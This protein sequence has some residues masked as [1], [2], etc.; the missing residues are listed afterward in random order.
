MTSP[1]RTRVRLPIVVVILLSPLFVLYGAYVVLRGV[2][3]VLWLPVRALRAVGRFVSAMRASVRCPSCRTP[4]AVRG[5][6]VCQ[7]CHAEYLGWVGRC[8]VC[9]AGAGWF[10]CASCGVG[11]RL[12]WVTS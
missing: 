3:F 7:R 1:Q 10:P 2:A 6:W 11:I 9:S 12:P 4:N 5:R 8:E